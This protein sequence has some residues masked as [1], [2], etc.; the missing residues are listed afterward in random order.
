MHCNREPARF[1]VR[2]LLRLTAA[3]ALSAALCLP[4]LAY[5]AGQKVFLIRG[6]ANVFSPGIDL[7][8]SELQARRI[9][10]ET[11]NHLSWSMTAS[12]AIE[13]CRSG[14]IS[15]IVLVGH[16]LGGAAVI[17]VAKRLQEAGM[18]V[19]LMV[20]LDPVSAG[21]APGNVRRL[22]NYYL[23]TGIGSSVKT[24]TGFRGQLQNVD[25][26]KRPGVDHVAMTTMPDIH[27]HI[28]A[29]IAAS[30][31]IPCR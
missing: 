22:E 28:I 25:V 17:D 21:Q 26:S 6:F 3:F 16:S 30:S 29:Q 9:N 15:S 5:A 23:S 8:A 4:S 2:H 7:L 12:E 18:R 13:G 20:T 31:G 10:V 19:A 24:D 1:T 11:S 27:K 14:Q